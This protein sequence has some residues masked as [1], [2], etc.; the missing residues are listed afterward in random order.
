MCQSGKA[1]QAGRSWK[2]SWSWKFGWW[3]GLSFADV[4]IFITASVK[5]ENQIK[6]IVPQYHLKYLSPLGLVEV[7]LRIWVISSPHVPMINAFP[8]L[9]GCGEQPGLQ[10]IALTTKNNI[11]RGP[12]LTHVLHF[13]SQ[14]NN[15]PGHRVQ[16]TSERLPDNLRTHLSI[17]KLS[18]ICF[19]D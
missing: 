10:H 14:Q 5:K 8:S 16:S 1:K 3:L 6:H 9:F 17:S 12:K 4:T 7:V 19:S 15:N 18:C 13:W 2:A 11:S